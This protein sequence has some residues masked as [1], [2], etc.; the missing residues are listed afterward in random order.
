MSKARRGKAAR[1]IHRRLAHATHT[2]HHH[3]F[4]HIQPCTARIQYVN[5]ISL[6][7]RLAPGETP[8]FEIY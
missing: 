1:L 5:W 4:V 3:V 2:R 8:V 7:N 6:D